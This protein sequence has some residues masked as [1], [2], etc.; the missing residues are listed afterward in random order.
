MAVIH[1]VVDTKD[2]QWMAPPK[3]QG[4]YYASLDVRELELTNEEI[5]EFSKKLAQLL[6]QSIQLQPP[7]G[8]EVLEL[9]PALTNGGVLY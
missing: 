7:S 4:I 8:S 3:L 5:E 9:S 2:R 1:L 6:L